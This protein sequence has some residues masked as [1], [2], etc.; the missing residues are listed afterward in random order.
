MKVVLISQMF[1]PETAAGANRVGAMARALAERFEVRVVTVAPSYP[2][3][4]LY[5]REAW[6]RSDR[7]LGVPILRAPAFLPHDAS[8]MRRALREIVMS[9]GL[10]RRAK[11]AE[12]A[13]QYTV[14]DHD[15]LARMLEEQMK[16]AAANMDF[17][18][19][20]TLRDQLFELKVAAK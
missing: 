6:E 3:P 11:V 12:P 4:A 9:F 7:E 8:L 10:V 20:A 19:A 14:M 15:A 5:A 17:E 2:D 13:R 16:E 18:L 1:P